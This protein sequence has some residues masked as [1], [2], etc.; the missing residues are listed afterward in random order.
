MFSRN[1]LFKLIVPLVI[2]QILNVTVGTVDSIMVSHAGEAAVSGVSLVNTLDTLLV[3]FFTALVGGGSV[4]V[5]QALGRKQTDEISEVAKQLIYIVTIVASLLTATV[6]VFRAPLLNLLFGDVEEAVM[7]SASDYFFY[8]ALSFPLLAITEGIGTCFRTSGHTMISLVVS[9]VINVVNVGGNAIL[10]RGF[11][12][13][14]KGAALA[15]LFSRLVG[16]VILIV[17]IHRK[18]Y[19]VHVE[20]SLRYRP[21]LQTIKKILYVG[22]PNGVENSM[23]QLGRLLTQTLI[24]TMPTSVIAA[25]AVALTICN[26]QYMTGTACSGATI[27]IVGRCFGADKK[28]QATYYSR[29]IL[30]LNYV[31]LWAVII[32][33]CIFLGP[34][35]SLYDLSGGTADLAK[36]LIIF[37][38]VVAALIWPI[39]FMLPSS[40]RSAGDVNF[41][42][43]V[44]MFSMWAFRVAG[45]Y[46]LALDAITI[47][48]IG[49]F[50]GFGMGIMGVWTAMMIDWVFRAA[51]YIWRYFS[52]VWLRKKRLV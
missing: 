44:S 4:V 14:A 49:T 5:A 17:L 22:I 37:H 29:V 9:F 24:A 15:T 51:L 18:R 46:L 40:F 47:P 27:P 33:T 52:G 48:F 8:V 39:G 34:L 30:A 25:N 31:I 3:I 35:V 43:V 36:E 2:Q 6:L 1:D 45:A 28:D 16:S 13:G 26:F 50:P 21:Q 7:T 42:M 12:L 10:I 11:S 20:N 38:S 41:T 32:F 23:F 19:P